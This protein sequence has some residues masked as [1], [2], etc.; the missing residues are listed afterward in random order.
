MP[1]LCFR[2]TS[3]VGIVS[4]LLSDEQTSNRNRGTHSFGGLLL[5][6]RHSRRAPN[7]SC[8]GEI[9]ERRT[10]A[11][12]AR[13]PIGQADFTKVTNSRFLT[14]LHNRSIAPATFRAIVR[15]TLKSA[16]GIS[17]ENFMGQRRLENHSG[18]EL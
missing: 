1:G 18:L 14:R 16:I 15:V 8:T 13:L 17:T 6:I 10:D 12:T 9:P 2:W 7:L 3:L 11:A 5:V 4:D